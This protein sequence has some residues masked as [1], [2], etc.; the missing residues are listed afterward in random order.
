MQRRVS[1]KFVALHKIRPEEQRLSFTVQRRRDGPLVKL[2]I[3]MTTH[4]QRFR[5]GLSK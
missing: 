5:L 2:S 4:D 3:D 1:H